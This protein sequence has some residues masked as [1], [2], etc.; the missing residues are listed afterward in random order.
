M[1]DNILSTPSIGEDVYKLIDFQYSKHKWDHLIKVYTYLYELDNDVEYL[2]FIIELGIITERLNAVLELVN[3]LI[4]NSSQIPLDYLLKFSSISI[5]NGLHDIGVNSLEYIL[6]IEKN[7]KAALR[8]LSEYYISKSMHKE[9]LYKLNILYKYEEKSLDILRM[10][11]ECSLII[12]DN[13]RA[14][15]VSRE[16]MEKFPDNIF[17][18]LSVARISRFMK[19]FNEAKIVLYEANKL[20]SNNP[21]IYFELGSTSIDLKMYD[22]ASGGCHKY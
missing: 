15:F 9:A 2:D 19:M 14:L 5:E 16:A 8:L 1:L 4:I 18:Y 17:G 7:N 20:F 12:A 3:S 13:D 10:I 6:S 21:Y 22:S 11:V